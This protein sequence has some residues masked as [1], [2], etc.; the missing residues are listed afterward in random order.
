MDRHVLSN[1]VA[2]ADLDAPGMHGHV[3]VLRHAADDG[4]LK[5]LIVG[6]QNR[7]RFHHDAGR[8]IAAVADDDA[9]LDDRERPYPN[10]RSNLGVGTD[11]SKRMN[12]HDG[13]PL[14][15]FEDFAVSLRPGGFRRHQSVSGMVE[16]RG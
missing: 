13:F 12:R 9:R 3:D 8:Q 1:H 5:D 6:A 16:E 15:K 10:V 11:D 14:E 2:A 4:P 7:A